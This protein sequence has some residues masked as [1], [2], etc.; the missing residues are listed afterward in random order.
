M[1]FDSTGGSSDS[2]KEVGAVSRA[3]NF[4]VVGGRGG[5]GMGDRRLRWHQLRWC[6]RRWPVEWAGKGTVTNSLLWPFHWVLHSL[7]SCALP[8]IKLGDTSLKKLSCRI[9]GASRCNIWIQTRF[10]Q[11]VPGKLDFVTHSRKLDCG[12][13][14]P[15]FGKSVPGL[16]ILIRA[17][18]GLGE[19]LRWF[20]IV[21]RATE[22]CLLILSWHVSEVLH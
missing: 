11:S 1:T 21:A 19:P 8:L 18:E 15:G 4:P 6:G 7:K 5:E 13:S 9:L 3:R 16:N 20:W 10:W 14:V 17:F 12:K 22:R 2:T